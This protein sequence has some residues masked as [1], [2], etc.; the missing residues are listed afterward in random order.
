MP[1]P[2]VLVVGGG[3]MGAAAARSLAGDGHSVILLEQFAFG[4]VRGSS[5]GPSRIFRFSY[6]DPDL[7]RMAMDALPLWRALEEEAGEELLAPADGIDTGKDLSDHI[8]A[9]SACGAAFEIAGGE[10]ISGRYPGVRLSPE[11]SVL[12]QRDAA[13]VAA[14]RAHRALLASATAA[15]A[16]LRS[17][18]RV[19]SLRAGPGTVAVDLDGGERLHAAVAVVTAG[20]WARSLLEGAGIYLDVR[21]TRESVAYFRIAGEIPPIVID[22]QTPAFYALPTPGYGIKAGRHRAGATIDP[23]ATGDPDAGSIAEVT[24]WVAER[25]PGAGDA[26]HMVET[27]LYTNTPDER[28]VLERYGSIVVG[29]PCSGHGFKFAPLVGERLADLA[30]R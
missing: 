10:E 20:A 13:V 15:G 2:D 1:S 19:R 18:V 14:D 12:V 3:V 5:H 11:R 4:H 17:N 29:S 28:F 7:V 21:P 8:A 27:C 24:R 16:D 25:F 6:P 22:W 30:R 9:L 23:D 26:P